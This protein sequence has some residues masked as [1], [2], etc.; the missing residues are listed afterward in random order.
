MACEAAIT[1]AGV[2]TEEACDEAIDT[3]AYPELA[4]H[5][6]ERSSI[7]NSLGAR[8]LKNTANA[9]QFPHPTRGATS[10]RCVS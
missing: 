6:G 4:R 3:A 1:A 2:F 7:Q 5:V 8:S 10:G 9:L